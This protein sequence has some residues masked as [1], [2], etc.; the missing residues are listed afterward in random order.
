MRLRFTGTDSKVGNCPAL[1]ESLDTREVVVQGR[2]LTNPEDLAQL[3]HFGAGD[4]AVVVPRELLVNWAP[5]EADPTPE[6]IDADEFA[7]LFRDFEHSA[8][9]LETRRGYA[10]D[11]DEAFKE[12][13]RTGVVVWEPDMASEWH[14][15]IRRQTDAGKAIG[16]V[17]VVDNPPTD[18]Q[19]FLLG[20]AACNAATGED[21][22][23]LWRS[24]AERLRL[25]EEDFWIFDSRLDVVLHFDESDELTSYE[26][27][28]EPAEVV[29]YSIARDAALHH[30]IP[31][32]QFAAQVAAMA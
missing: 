15:N 10:S 25:L 26:V 22:R 1:H 32:D 21:A 9:H 19:R 31:H 14:Q 27:K 23:C 8:W 2:P 13:L 29:R 17:R 7:R 30:A 12:F 16:R 24:D 20:Y 5:K 4:A 18:G 3:Q 6:V 28:T 11:R